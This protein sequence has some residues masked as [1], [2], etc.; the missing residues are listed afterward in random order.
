MHNELLKK[1][2]AELKSSREEKQVTLN[3]IAAKTRIDI[4]Y[5]TAIENAHFEVLPELYIRA[6]IKEYAYNVDLNPEET[7]KKFD[8]AKAGKIETVEESDKAPEAPS[9]IPKQINRPI[10]K[11]FETVE[12]E[13]YNVPTE[14]KKTLDPRILYSIMGTVVIIIIASL[15]FIFGTSTTI[16]KDSAVTGASRYDEVQ[17]VRQNT[18][19]PT[20]SLKLSITANSLVWFEVSSDENTPKQYLFKD[21]Q[22]VVVT[23]K[24]KFILNV[25]NA[26]GLKLLLNG[27][28]LDPIGNPGE[29]KFV[30]IDKDGVKLLTIE[31]PKNEQPAPGN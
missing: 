8:F 24:T 20:D 10:K 31:R 4:K 13:A 3:Q 30:Q 16:E 26:G 17:Q 29:V 25:G 6:F 23:A 2:A 7:I 28:Q 5:L 11:H 12:T 18:A 19:L 14:T 27:K 21:Q 9:E 22:S 1:F 15:Y